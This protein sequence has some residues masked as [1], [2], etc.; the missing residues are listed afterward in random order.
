[1]PDASIMVVEGAERFGLAQLHQLRGRVGRAGQ[2]AACLL[3]YT[4]PLSPPQVERLDLLRRENEGLA[5]AEA[6]LRLRGEGDALG[7]RQSGGVA[8]R[9]VD[10]GRDGAW[11]AAIAGRLDGADLATFDP[12][13]LFA[14][15]PAVTGGLGAG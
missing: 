7:I 15:Q 3:L 12:R 5:L 6:D 8:F 14:D 9:F 13:W 4:P 11:L 1:V 2:E 10:W